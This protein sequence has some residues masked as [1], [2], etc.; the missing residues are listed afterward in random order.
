MKIKNFTKKCITGSLIL[1]LV[2]GIIA[3][4]GFA[5]TGFSTHPFEEANGHHW[6]QTIYLEDGA[7]TY[8]VKISEN[9]SIIKIGGKPF[10]LV[11]LYVED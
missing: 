4:S 9:R 3:S 5:M 6:Y 7:W 11:G 10:N 8:G 2:G 1:L